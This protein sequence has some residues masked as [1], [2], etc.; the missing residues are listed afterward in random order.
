MKA[1]IKN[2]T[3]PVLL[4]QREMASLVGVEECQLRNGHTRHS[5]WFICLNSHGSLTFDFLEFES[6]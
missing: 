6:C 3:Q 5:H 1:E 2:I 4:S